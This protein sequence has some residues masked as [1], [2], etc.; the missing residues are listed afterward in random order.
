MC[1]LSRSM[2]RPSECKWGK[3]RGVT[4]AR[5]NRC[6]LGAPSS[7]GCNQAPQPSSWHVLAIGT[8][9]TLGCDPQQENILQQANAEACTCESQH[10]A[11]HIDETS[12]AMLTWAKITLP[13]SHPY[14]HI[15]HYCFH[16]KIKMH[17]D[18]FQLHFSLFWTFQ[19]WVCLIISNHS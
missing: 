16:E 14:L 15:L 6:V 3:I 12:P 17:M 5:D 11:V 10:L 1:P 18:M 13:F 19:S 4:G 2:D 8:I 9:R 7:K